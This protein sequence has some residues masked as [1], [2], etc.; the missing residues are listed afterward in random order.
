MICNLAKMAI[1]DASEHEKNNAI[2]E[3][4][5]FHS[6]HEAWAVLKEETEEMCQ[7][8]NRGIFQS[9]LYTLWI[10]VKADKLVDKARLDEVRE[11]A[12]AA[13]CECVQVMAMCD[14]WRKYHGDS[15]DEES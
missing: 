2:V 3:H 6:Q 14:K 15:E 9:M 1:E 8:I 13:A 7:A 5:Y 10:D 12:F 4:G 11:A